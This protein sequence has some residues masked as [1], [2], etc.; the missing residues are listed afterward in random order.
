MP[1]EAVDESQSL[2]AVDTGRS[3][4]TVHTTISRR[5]R[6]RFRLDTKIFS[7]KIQGIQISRYLKNLFKYTSD[8]QTVTAVEEMFIVA[9]QDDY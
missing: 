4:P 9:P 2:S 5:P 6:A 1:L 7:T 3:P 8:R